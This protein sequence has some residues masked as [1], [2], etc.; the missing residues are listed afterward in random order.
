MPARPKSFIVPKSPNLPKKTFDK[1]ILSRAI[2]SESVSVRVPGKVWD[3]K[4]AAV[5][6]TG[7]ILEPGLL[8]PF[9]PGSD[10]IPS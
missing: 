9:I 4:V 1:K 7:Y 8:L 10:K 2:D 6:S 5:S 3:R